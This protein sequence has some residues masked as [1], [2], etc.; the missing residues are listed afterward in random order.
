MSESKTETAT[1]EE[2]II[3]YECSFT[4]ERKEWLNGSGREARIKFEGYADN[5][6]ILGCARALK[7]MD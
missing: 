3:R 4:M 2:S 7:E 6:L 5:D 1:L